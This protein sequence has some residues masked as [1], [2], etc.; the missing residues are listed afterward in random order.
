MGRP[1]NAALR[2][3]WR[4]RIARQLRSELSVADFC[5]QERLSLQ[6]FY[7]WRRRLRED[8]PPSLHSPLFLPV[9]LA[10]GSTRSGDGLRIELPG[11]VVMTVPADAPAEILTTAIHAVMSGSSLEERG[12]C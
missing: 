2:S 5:R 1:V 4:Q 11:G 3:M 9:E 6:S 10:P 8:D 7:A 12:P